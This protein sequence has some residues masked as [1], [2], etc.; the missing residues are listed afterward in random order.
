MKMNIKMNMKLAA[1]TG[2]ASGLTLLS[3]IAASYALGQTGIQWP[4][5]VTPGAAPEIVGSGPLPALELRRDFLRTPGP[6]PQLLY[7]QADRRVSSQRV[8]QLGS[9]VRSAEQRIR[10]EQATRAG[11]ER[12]LKDGGLSAER[13]A[14]LQERLRTEERL[15]AQGE[16]DLAR[17]RADLAVAK[18]LMQQPIRVTPLRSVAPSASQP[19]SLRPITRNL[20]FTPEDAAQT[21]VSH[22]LLTPDTRAVVIPLTQP[23]APAIANQK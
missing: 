2:A 12:A 5:G 11:I 15:L 9:D 1:V 20:L 17:K 10:E 21:S 18:L 22:P 3:P 6:N 8:Q 23:D 16:A 13:R 14:Q 19:L 4:S 7:V